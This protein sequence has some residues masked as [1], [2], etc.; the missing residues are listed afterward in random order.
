MAIERVEGSYMKRFNSKWTS[1]SR[2]PARA[3]MVALFAVPLVLLPAAPAMAEGSQ[4]CEKNGNMYCIGAPNLAMYAPVI[5]TVRGRN[6]TVSP[7]NGTLNTYL[8]SI[9]A[10]PEHDECVAAT[11]N[12][13]DVV[14]HPCT[15]AGVEWYLEFETDPHYFRMRSQEFPNKYLAGFGVAGQ[16]FQLKAPGISGWYYKFF[17]GSRA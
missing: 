11:N 14:I 3:L 16:Q 17:L 6:L 4:V 1:R 8:I 2:R 7:L 9:D 15:G 12:G 10:A 5:E 13:T